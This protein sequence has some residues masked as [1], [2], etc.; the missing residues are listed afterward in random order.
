MSCIKYFLI[1]ML[2]IPFYSGVIMAIGQIYPDFMGVDALSYIYRAVLNYY[3]LAEGSS[4]IFV[5]GLY[6]AII[7][8]VSILYIREMMI[9]SD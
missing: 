8:F 7:S 4:L 2:I 6:I 9:K 3:Q 1:V 5:V